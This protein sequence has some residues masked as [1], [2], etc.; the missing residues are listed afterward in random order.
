MALTRSQRRRRNAYVFGG[1]FALVIAMNGFAYAMVPAYRAFCQQFGFAG[2]PIVEANGPESDVVLRDRTITV[3][4]NSDIAPD[5][6]WRFKP[7]QRR[8]D[9]NPGE[10]GLAFYE[11]VNNAERDVSG[12]ATFNVTPLKAAPYFVKIEC[13]CFTEQTL[14][15]G[16]VAQMPV[17]FYVDPA[18]A[19]DQN[20]DDVTTI[21]LSYTFFRDMDAKTEQAAAAGDAEEAK[22]IQVN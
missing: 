11:A 10:T 4:F 1:L 8:I 7:V 16:Q 5:L 9:L 18:I 20:L 14:S 2:T 13:F 15:P 17:T 6:D 22:K 3:R 19:E 21:T 12:T